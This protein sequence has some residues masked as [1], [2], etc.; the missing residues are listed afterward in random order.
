MFNR[1]TD[2]MGESTVRSQIRDIVR[3]LRMLPQPLTLS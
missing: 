2:C 1:Y 3:R